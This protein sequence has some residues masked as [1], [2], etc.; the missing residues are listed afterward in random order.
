MLDG[1]G[2]GAVQ[3]AVPFVA[4]KS[5]PWPSAD[6]SNAV[7]DPMVRRLCG[8]LVAE[9]AAA[10]HSTMATADLLDAF[11]RGEIARTELVVPI[12]AAKATRHAPHYTRRRRSAR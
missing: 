7:D 4:S 5:R 1:I 8:E 9:L 3:A 10:Y 6:V 11:E 2:I 12:H